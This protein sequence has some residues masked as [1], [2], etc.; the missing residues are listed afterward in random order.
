MKSCKTVI[1]DGRKLMRKIGFILLSIAIC[2]ITI[3]FARFSSFFEVIQHN[4][5]PT[6]II[7]ATIP[8][9]GAANNYSARLS[10]KLHGS[11]KKVCLFFIGFDINIP[12]ETVSSQIPIFAAVNLPKPNITQSANLSDNI[13]YTSEFSAEHDD[14]PQENRAP[15]KSADLSSKSNAEGKISIGNETTYSVNTERLLADAVPISMKG[16]GPKVLV[17]HTHATEAYSPHGSTVYD[18]SAG[19]RNTDTS[20]NVVKVGDA[21]CDVFNKKGIKAIHDTQLHDYPSFNGA[22]AHSLA[23]TEQYISQYPSIQIVIDIHRDSIVYDDKTKIKSVTQINGRDTAQLMLVVGTDQN[24]LYNPDWEQRLNT[25]IHF[26]NEI[27]RR[28]PTLMRHINLRRE[29]FN[30]HAA[31]GSMII[32]TGTSGNSLDEAVYAI[33]LAGECIA[34]YLNSLS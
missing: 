1:I 9:A 26:Q 8:S 25:A 32:E 24:G 13:D 16:D 18:I 5:I 33:T 4:I 14:I 15:I 20:H 29:R 34:D 10:E 11:I 2:G 6:D 22:Y 3:R 30:G 12:S 28:Y 7:S 27:I 19:D 17:I 31:P 23:A 21:I